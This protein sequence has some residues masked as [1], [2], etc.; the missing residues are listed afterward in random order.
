MQNFLF[1]AELAEL[2]L[3]YNQTQ[4]HWQHTSTYRSL[5]PLRRSDMILE[6]KKEEKNEITE[7]RKPHQNAVPCDV[8]ANM[9]CQ[10]TSV[11]SLIT[12]FVTET[13]MKA[14]IETCD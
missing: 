1:L 6:S 13:V 10:I 5:S 11:S 2:P 3:A 7:N 14:W 4:Y 9:Q 8:N 12:I